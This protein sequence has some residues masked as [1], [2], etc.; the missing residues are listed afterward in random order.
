MA[1]SQWEN[2]N[3]ADVCTAWWFFQD[4]EN[5]YCSFSSWH[6]SHSPVT[7][8]NKPVPKKHVLSVVEWQITQIFEYLIVVRGGVQ[9]KPSCKGT[10]TTDKM[11]E[12]ISSYIWLLQVPINYLKGKVIVNWRSLV[13][14]HFHWR[15]LCHNGERIQKKKVN[16]SIGLDFTGTPISESLKQLWS[17]HSKLSCSG[18]RFEWKW[19]QTYLSKVN[20][21][22][23]ES[24]PTDHCSTE[25]CWFNKLK[26]CSNTLYSSIFCMEGY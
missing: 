3:W 15:W 19:K 26:A 11:P 7:S 9:S 25:Q 16:V 14:L 5:E 1:I 20:T 4:I 2:N 10:R 12:V 13:N 8:N 18:W 22:W 17:M 21:E 6:K 24:F 23:V